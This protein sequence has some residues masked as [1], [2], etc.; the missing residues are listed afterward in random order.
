MLCKLQAVCYVTSSQNVTNFGLR[1]ITIL[2]VAENKRPT[3]LNST[4]GFDFDLFTVIS[5]GF[6]T[7]L[8][9]FIR[10]RRSSTKLWR[11]IY[12]FQDGVAYLLPFS[13]MV[14]VSRFWRYKAI[15]IPNF[16][17]ISQSAAD[18]LLLPVPK[19]KRS[20]YWNSTSGFYSDR[21][22]P[23]SVCDPAQAQQI[24]SKFDDR[25]RIYEAISIL[26][27]GGHSVA[28]LYFWFLVWPCFTF[29]LYPSKPN[30]NLIVYKELWMEPYGNL[31]TVHR[32]WRCLRRSR[33]YACFRSRD[34]QWCRR[35][36]R[37]SRYTGNRYGG[38][39]SRFG[40]SHD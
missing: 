37:K 12:F 32:F 21:Y 31:T 6:C 28:N 17:L 19:R 27:D 40:I 2:A 38:R 35:C 26:Q 34:V 18:I 39:P 5:I 20:P 7:S 23:S 14:I 25:R 33:L 36:H 11:H 16:D 9:N 1:Y 29:H 4:P 3:Y 30:Y 24:L 8:R 22:T 10:I 15:R 13:S